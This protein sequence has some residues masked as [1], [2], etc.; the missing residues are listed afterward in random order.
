MK[1]KS[2]RNRERVRAENKE[3][4]FFDRNLTLKTGLPGKLSSRDVI[5]MLVTLVSGSSHSSVTVCSAY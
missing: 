4:P 1:L 2:S 3:A 5:Q